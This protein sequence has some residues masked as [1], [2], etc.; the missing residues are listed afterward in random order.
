MAWQ[1]GRSAGGELEEYAALLSQ[2][3]EDMEQLQEAL[4]ATAEQY[5]ALLEEYHAAGGE[6]EGPG[7]G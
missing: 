4:A 5:E 3:H 7:E 2:L 6:V 1:E